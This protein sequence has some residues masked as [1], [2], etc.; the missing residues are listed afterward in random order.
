MSNWLARVGAAT[1]AGLSMLLLASTLGIP[2]GTAAAAEKEKKPELT[3]EVRVKLKPAQDAVGKED[4]DGCIARANEALAITKKPY[5]KEMAL[6]FLAQC[7]AKKQ[8]YQAYAGTVEQLDELDIV[9]ADEKAR[10]YKNLA[11]I[12]YQSKTFDKAEKAAKAWAQATNSSDAYHMLMAIYYSQQDCQNAVVAQ[13]KEIA[14][15]KAAGKDASEQSLKILNSCYFKL[16]EKAKREVVME[17]LLRRFPKADY[18]TDL[19][20]IYTT[21][22]KQDKNA[23]LEIY[24]YGFEREWISRESIFVEFVSDLLDAGAPAEAARVIEA[25]AAKGAFPVIA[26]TDRNGRL[27]AKAAQQAAEDRKQIAQLDKEARAKGNGEADVTVGLAYLGLGDNA[28]AVEALE[29]GLSAERIAK[30]KRVDDAR[31]LLG[32]A[33]KRLGKAEEAKQAFTAAAQ[34]PRMAKAAALW[35]QAF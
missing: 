4:W 5:D 17:E 12:Y 14:I 26:A 33:Y 25:A 3:E 27:K 21:D 7:Q 16:G 11:S 23:V 22:D 30:V 29:R 28:K 10:N 35:L 6:R 1:A 18:Y 13:E 24:R 34:D 32:I 31:M 2:A 19:R 9:T 15:D 8:D 20:Q